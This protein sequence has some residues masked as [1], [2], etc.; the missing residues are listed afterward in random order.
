VR[1]PP[2]DLAIRQLVISAL[3]LTASAAALWFLLPAH[4]I[5]LPAFFAW[6]AMAGGG[7]DC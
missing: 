1:L 3:D 6:Y 2:P 4:I 7:S 5:G